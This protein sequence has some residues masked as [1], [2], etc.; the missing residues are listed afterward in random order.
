M[1][2]MSPQELDI[3]LISKQLGMDVNKMLTFIFDKENKAPEN[4]ETPTE[5]EIA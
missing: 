5:V 1:F 3:V 2:K 4:Y